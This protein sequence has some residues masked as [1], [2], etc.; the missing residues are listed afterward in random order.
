MAYRIRML[1]AAVSGLA[2]TATLTSCGALGLAGD[3][4]TT[5]RLV[6]ANYGSTSADNSRIY[7]DRL[8]RAYERTHPDVTIDVTVYDWK[9]VDNKIAAMVRDGHAPDIA[10][11]GSYA[12]YAAQDK[13]YSA[14]DLLDVSSQSDIISS[15]AHA[16]TVR[17]QEYGLPF[18]SSTR[19]LFYNKALFSRAGIEREPR[20]WADLKADA[21]ALKAIGVKTPY[22]LPLGPEEAQAESLIWMLGNGGG[23]TGDM[24]GDYV[25]DSSRNVETFSWLKRN[26]VGAG[27][28]G[29]D[30]AT[31]N[32]QDVFDAFLAGDAGM[33]MGHPTLLAQARRKGIDVGIARIPG[34]TKALDNTLG[35]ADWMMAFKQNGH[36]QQIGDFLDYVYEDKNTVSF[37]DEYGLLPVTMSASD[38][39]RADKKYKS[40]WPFIERLPSAVFYP[41]DKTSWGAVSAQVKQSIGT[42]ASTGDPATVLRRLQRKAAALDAAA[43]AD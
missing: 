29:T 2:L 30:P 10:Q 6:A 5:L 26:L 25:I 23:F 43:K 12:G 42:A 41:A 36:R 8:A 18:V 21:Q 9:D 39:M 34:R 27:L 22:G 17:E 38:A 40:L 35:V 32:R 7:W 3:H 20:T 14:E 15:L 33:I 31:T 37:L 11:A 28:T 24:S 16:G 1:T 4:V 19:L 13:L